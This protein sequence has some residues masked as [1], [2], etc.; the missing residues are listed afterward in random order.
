MKN[1]FESFGKNLGGGSKVERQKRKKTQVFFVSHSEMNIFQEE[2]S[3][4][5]KRNAAALVARRHGITGKIEISEFIE[6]AGI[7]QK[8]VRIPQS[9]F[10]EQPQTPEQIVSA[11]KEKIEALQK[12][13]SLVGNP[14][15]VMRRSNERELA[16]LKKRLEKFQQPELSLMAK[17]R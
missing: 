16:R 11:I 6:D 2:V 8:N 15:P 3:A 12:G 10:F 7:E 9:S 13:M 4:T 17:T 14:N 1:K 5:T